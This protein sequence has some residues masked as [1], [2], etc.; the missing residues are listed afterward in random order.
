M[1]ET[2]QL[3]ARDETR[4]AETAPSV[5]PGIVRDSHGKPRIGL[6]PESLY[7]FGHLIRLAA[8]RHPLFG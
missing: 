5:L 7:A 6:G 3:A 2:L 1:T 4:I 8:S